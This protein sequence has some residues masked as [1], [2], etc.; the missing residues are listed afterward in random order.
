MKKVIKQKWLKALRSGKYKQGNGKLRSKDNYC[1]LGVL[2]I[3][4]GNTKNRDMSQQYPIQDLM[5]YTNTPKEF[6]GLTNTQQ[7]KLASLN[8]I[9]NMS[10]KEI[11]AYISRNIK[12]KD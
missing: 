6:C 9:C 1:C 11:A 4:T 10:F 8:D 7:V 2:C 12:T 3:V 5:G